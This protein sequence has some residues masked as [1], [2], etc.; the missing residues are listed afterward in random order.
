MTQE[1]LLAPWRPFKIKPKLDFRLLGCDFNTRLNKN[2]IYTAHPAT[3]QPDWQEK[4]K[5]FV[6]FDDDGQEPSILLDQFD[7]EIIKP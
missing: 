6:S 5:V 2:K 1:N 7:Y 3:N 4:G